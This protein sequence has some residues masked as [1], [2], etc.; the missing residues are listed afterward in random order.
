MVITKNLPNGKTCRVHMT[1][2]DSPMTR[3]QIP[4]IDFFS[5]L[6]QFNLKPQM[7]LFWDFFDSDFILPARMIR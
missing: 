6:M 2:K 3:F 1:R 7:R 4:G 5:G